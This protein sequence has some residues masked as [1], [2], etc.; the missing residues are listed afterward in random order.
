MKGILYLCGAGNSEGVRLAKRVSENTA[1]WNRIVLLD[2]DDRK[3]GHSVM[4]VT[5]EGPFDALER[6]NR[7]TDS[8]Q[9]LVARTTRGREAAHRKIASYGIP[10]TDLISPAVDTEGVECESGVIVY[11]NVTLGPEVTIGESSVIFMGAVVGHEC[12]VGRGCVVASNAVLN[13]RVVLEDQVYVGTNATILPEITIGA[14]ATIGAGSVVLSDVP[15][16]AT[17]FGVPAKTVD[18]VGKPRQ[19]LAASSMSQRPAVTSATKGVDELEGMIA[20]IWKDELGIAEVARD[21][22][23]FDVGGCSLLALRVGARISEAM[24]LDLPASDIFRYPTIHALALHIGVG[25]DGD[26]AVVH[27]SQRAALRRGL[28]GRRPA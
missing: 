18:G 12:K 19:S 16:G 7:T 5:V 14:G 15:A 3:L 9:N 4:G 10:F 24:H 17:V 6:A 22:N 25:G 13:A 27:G 21:E 8:V 23:F 26:S 2:D 20:S 1:Q 28:M 11:H